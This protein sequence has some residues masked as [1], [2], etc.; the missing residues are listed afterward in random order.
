MTQNT[1]WCITRDNL[2][3]LW[4]GTKDGLNR[5]DG[6]RFKTFRHNPDDAKSIGNN[7]IRSIF[8]ADDGLIWVGTDAGLYIYNSI[9]ESFTQFST[10]TLNGHTIDKEVNDIKSDNSGNLW[11]A[12]N[13]QGLFKYNLHSQK[14]ILFHADAGN[15]NSIS[16]NFIWSI[17]VDRDEIVWVGTHQG[18]LNR[19]NPKTEQFDH[20]KINFNSENED[21]YKIIEDGPKNILVG[22]SNGGVYSFDRITRQFTPFISES[23]NSLFVRDIAIPN[24]D[25]IWLG[26]ESG[27]FVYNRKDKKITKIRQEFGDKYAL[28]CNSIYC[29]F[30]DKIGDI[31]IGTYFGGIN[32]LSNHDLSFEKH[33]PSANL[34]RLSGK[35]VREMCEDDDGTIWI[36]TEDNGLNAF[37]P[38]SQQFSRYLPH[39]SNLSYHNIHGLLLDNEELWIGYFTK[40][41]DILNTKT[42]KVKHL[43]TTTSPVKLSDNNVFSI[44]KDNQSNIW[45]GTINGLNKFSKTTGAMEY[46]QMLGL[47]TFIYDILQ[48]NNGVMWFG[49][50]GHGLYSFNPRTNEWNNLKHNSAN[51][52]SIAHNKIIGLF[53]DSKS[54]LWIS[55]EGGGVSRYDIQNNIFTNY[56][57]KNGLPNDIIYKV[58]EDNE[59]YIWFSSNKG[60]VRLHP[61]DGTIKMFSSNNG[62]V[63]DQFNY[64]SGLKTQNGKIYFGSIN[65]FVGFNP[66]QILANKEIPPIVFTGFQVFNNEITV[67]EDSPIDRSITHQPKIKLKHNQ[68]TFSFDFAALSYSASKMNQYAYIMENYD[69]KWTITNK[70]QRVTYPNMPFGKYIFKVKGANSDGVWNQEGTFVEIEVLP[71]FWLSRWAIAAYFA[72]FVL[73]IYAYLNNYKIKLNIKHKAKIE[74]MKAE[75]EKALQQTKIELFT[76]LAHEIRTPLSLIKA[77][78]EQIVKNGSSSEDYSENLKIMGW[79]INRLLNLINQLL[80][81]RK[82][83]SNMLQIEKSPTPIVSLCNEITDNYL[84][85]IKQKGISFTKS[86]PATD[87]IADIDREAFIKIIT[88]LMNNALKFAVKSIIFKVEKDQNNHSN[89]LTLSISNDGKKI[90]SEYRN[91]IF[92]PFFQINSD[93]FKSGTGLGLPLVKHMV[94][95]HCGTASVNESMDGYTIFEITIPISSALPNAF[96]E[97][98][99]NPCPIQTIPNEGA[100]NDPENHPNH[101]IDSIL[102]VE[103]DDPM[104]EFLSGFLSKQFRILEAENGEK[105]MEILENESIDLIVSDISMPKITGI[106]LCEKIKASSELCHIPII[107]LTAK[108]STNSKIIGLEAGADAYIEKP[109]STD[110]LTTQ[111]NNLLNNRAILKQVFLSNP[112]LKQPEITINKADAN[113]L[114]KINDFIL[115]NLV[116]ESF[117]IDDLATLLNTSRS[118]LHRKIRGILNITPNDYIRIIKLKKAAELL[119]QGIY[120]INEISYLVG[121]S[122]SSYFSKCFQ[123]QF[124]VLP[125]EYSKHH[126]PYS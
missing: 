6:Y 119:D 45:I 4:F 76:N 92:E 61:E 70:N 99:A 126:S 50:Y 91:R 101:E 29:I 111:I 44:Y 124:G 39:N 103:D 14:L 7:F 21:I 28:S 113:F 20:F 121:F 90:S 35:A 46:I 2:G 83:E 85:T 52:N 49:T 5:Y 87:F 67:G 96:P 53:Q 88:N 13:W 114:L 78:Y 19:F 16:S 117:N 42:G 8:V 63:N 68:N 47:N 112:H 93:E 71:P 58:L 59:G 37:N 100:S 116:N 30:Q 82:L 1:V 74:R 125:K 17:C 64:K 69:K 24:H 25:E 12:V 36:G 65:G 105:A 84:T 56:S 32:Y 9:D 43:S 10:P 48:D 22:T 104:R 115:E 123:K 89:S 75:K 33:Y 66:S 62:L 15:K 86:F 41:I 55:T 26:T 77:P 3:F 23:P 107:L 108:I 106:E 102:L 38:V 81:F 97:P 27:L 57:T 118:T 31:W 109:F 95:L 73:L 120:R 79:N 94:E 34:N 11:I 51:S 80:D 40:G 72:S 98:K 110:H 18:G 122:S 54:R 60:I